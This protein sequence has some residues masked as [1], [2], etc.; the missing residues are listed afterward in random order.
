MDLI[1][2][3]FKNKKTILIFGLSY[4]LLFLYQ[5]DFSFIDETDNMLG[6]LSIIHGKDIYSGFISQHVPFVYYLT[7]IFALLGVREYET[8]R[9]CMSLVTLIVWVF[10]YI[11]YKNYFGSNTIKLFIIIYPLTIPLHWGNMILSDIFEGYAL[12]FLVLEFIMYMETKTLTLKNVIIISISIFV[13]SM[14]AFVS[15]YPIFIIIMGVFLFYIFQ[16]KSFNK[17]KRNL[18]RY[19]LFCLVISIPF[20]ILTLFYL[21]TGNLKN[22]YEQA[23]LF[24]RLYY[25]KYLGGFGVSAL[26]TFK[27]VPTAWVNY[28]ASSIFNIRKE[29]IIHLCFIIF[30]LLFVLQFYKRNLYLSIVIFIYLGFLGV[31]GYEDFHAAPYYIVSI[32]FTS[33]IIQRFLI[34]NNNLKINDYKLTFLK[35]VTFVFFLFAVN[36]YLPKMGINLLKPSGLITSSPYD[37]YTQELT[38]VNDKVW[39]SQIYPQSYL[40]NHREPASRA[41]TIVPWFADAYSE[42]VISDLKKSNPKMI[43]FEKNN[44]VWGHKYSDFAAQIFEYIKANYTILNEADP[45]ESNIYIL[46][47]YYLDATKKLWPGVSGITDGMLISDSVNVYLIENGLKRH[48]VNTEVFESNGFEWGA[49]KKMDES[50]VSKIKTGKLIDSVIS[51]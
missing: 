39:Y 47:D 10:M 42:L 3:A 14:S 4:L 20:V 25:T 45:I 12:L 40:H 30:N 43:T 24:N 31:R 15:V 9:L 34:N 11:N 23:Y 2:M 13:S 46:N 1:N 17:Y 7:S 50:I 48:I 19:L 21:I 8:F 36:G 38:T 22:F 51:K 29:S 28:I 27:Q 41:Y 6:G 35:L 33:Y 49:V 44:E 37:K 5:R 26:A 18:K 16:N 32:F